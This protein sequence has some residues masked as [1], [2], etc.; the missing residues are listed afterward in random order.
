MSSRR[1][2]VVEGRA[3]RVEG[4]LGPEQ[5]LDV[6]RGAIRH[7]TRTGRWVRLRRRVV[8]VAGAPPTWRQAV[9]AAL[10]AAG[11]EAFLSHDTACKIYGLEGFEDPGQIE[12]SAAPTARSGSPA[13]CGLT[14]TRRWKSRT[15]S[16]D[17]AF[18][19]VRESGS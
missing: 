16:P 11:D 7:R 12:M 15:S 4:L 8:R 10:M 14:G 5:L 19:S 17:R 1:G 2:R 6:G 3:E 13:A 9:T 18:G